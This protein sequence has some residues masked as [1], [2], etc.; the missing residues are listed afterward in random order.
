MPLSPGLDAASVHGFT[1]SGVECLLVSSPSDA[2]L[3]SREESGRQFLEYTWNS[4][5]CGACIFGFWR[6]IKAGERLGLS[7]VSHCVWFDFFLESACVVVRYYISKRALS[8]FSI[9]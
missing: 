6:C 4:S 3:S 7:V 1:C 5:Q 8:V 2:T 9:M